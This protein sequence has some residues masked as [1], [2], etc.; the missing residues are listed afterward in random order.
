[1][2]G[3]ALAQVQLPPGTQIT[4][5][6]RFPLPPGTPL[7]TIPAACHVDPAIVSIT[8]T[9]GALRGQVRISYEIRNLGRSAW[10]SGANQQGAHLIAHNGNTGTDF[11]NHRPLPG[12]AAA[13]AR[14]TLYTSPLINNAFDDFEFGGHVDLSIG[15][16]P[17]IAIDGNTCNDDANAANNRKRIENAAILGFMRGTARTQ[18]F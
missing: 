7:P 18:R 14:M 13:G 6:P 10:R 16:D 2:A 3:S 9:K 15:Y 11:I 5:A 12:A 17:D 8:L 4:P 1:M